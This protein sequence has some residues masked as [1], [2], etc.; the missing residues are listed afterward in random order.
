MNTIENKQFPEE[1]ALYA[2]EDIKLVNCRFEGEE[3]GESALKE[4]RNISAEHCLFDL[5]YPLWHCRNTLISQCT[6][7][8]NC[9]AAM[10]YD[11][12][13]VVKDSILSGIKAVRECRG[14]T[15]ERSK[16]ISPE[17]GWRS[18][19]IHI[20][21][22]EITSEYAFFESRRLTADGLI[23]HGKYTFQYVR[24][25]DMRNCEFHTKDAFWHS[26]NVTVRN[27]VLDG[28]YLGWY[29][30][31]LTLINCHIR[32]T[33][34]LCYC[35]NLTLINCTTE[36]CDLAF[37]YS[38]VRADIKGGIISVKN[39]LRGK[40]CADEIGETVLTDDSRQPVKAKIFSG[41]KRTH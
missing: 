31:G 40:I 34:P 21:D 32:G 5:R 12:N 6:A 24:R 11:A 30:K 41:G 14:V 19:D 13:I 15:I 25:A 28:E 17:F 33:Q 9:R 4:C 35:K 8:E 27:S 26:E 18:L 10:W 7:T 22:A 38:S 2:A 36:D 20:K 3:D 37:E 1:R 23:L 39:P 16:I 29:S